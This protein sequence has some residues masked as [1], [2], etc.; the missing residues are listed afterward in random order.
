MNASLLESVSA[1]ANKHLIYSCILE[2]AVLVRATKI[3]DFVY[4]SMVR[5]GIFNSSLLS[6]IPNFWVVYSFCISRPNFV[7]NDLYSRLIS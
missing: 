4:F 7:E 1:G 5:D 2:N 3:C 6:S